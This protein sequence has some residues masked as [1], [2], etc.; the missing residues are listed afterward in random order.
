MLGV[1]RDPAR[2]LVVR[3]GNPLC[4]GETPGGLYFASLPDELPG[5]VTPIRDNYAGVLAYHD[6]DL[7][8]VARP[9]GS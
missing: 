8:H 1:W 4:F 3:R 9:I 2:L 7:R 5:E 6:G